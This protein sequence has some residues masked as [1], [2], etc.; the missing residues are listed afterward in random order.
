MT[1]DVERQVRD[2]VRHADAQ[3][4]L[5]E[6]E[7]L[8]LGLEQLG[9][10]MRRPRLD[11]GLAAALAAAAAVIV[12]VGG[13]LVALRL[14]GSR[15]PVV[16]EPAPPVVP[17]TVPMVVEPATPPPTQAPP[18]DASASDVIDY[19]AVAERVATMEGPLGPMEWWTSPRVPAAWVNEGGFPSPSFTF[20]TSWIPLYE[21]A[22]EGVEIFEVAGGYVGL[23]T[24]VE[25]SYAERD[26]RMSAMWYGAL[27]SP[28]IFP[29]AVWFSPDGESW[30][31]ML[32]GPIEPGE[33]SVETHHDPDVLAERDGRFVLIGWA[34]AVSVGSS[35][36]LWDDQGN[37]LE[38]GAGSVVVGVDGKGDPLLFDDDGNLLLFDDDGNPVGRD[39][40]TDA[41]GNP[42]DVVAAVASGEVQVGPIGGAVDRG[43]P[44]AWVSDDL[45]TWERVTADFE[46]PGMITDIESVA[47]T[48]AGWFIFGTRRTDTSDGLVRRVAEWAAWTSPD[49]KV[50]EEFPIGDLFDA[51]QVCTP[52]QGANCIRMKGAPAPGGGVA[53]YAYEWDK[54]ASDFRDLTWNLR[55]GFPG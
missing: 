5:V 24:D 43:R 45:V 3:V 25:D 30:E 21:S 2:Y 55:I 47:A 13:A 51:P 36:G 31:L 22:P 42:V 29:E 26:R 46:K 39:E 28:R 19:A 53:V 9:K 49:G 4:E 20:K 38:S 16:T 37:Q 50:W 10:P 1:I 14:G 27:G 12:L 52:S 11:R 32:D 23:T 33:F 18:D 35:Y 17:T 6:I 15:S 44:M 48:D 41:D 7:E 34:D 8:G 54:Q 40:V